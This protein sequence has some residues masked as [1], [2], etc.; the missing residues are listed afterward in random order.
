MLIGLVSILAITLRNSAGNLT[1]SYCLSRETETK[2]NDSHF[3]DGLKVMIKT[4]VEG[5]SIANLL[6]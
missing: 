6:P 2:E 5:I 3:V 4:V 1:S